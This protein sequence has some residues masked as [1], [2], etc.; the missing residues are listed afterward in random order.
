MLDR[1]TFGCHTM[2]Q[3]RHGVSAF[4]ADGHIRYVSHTVG[5]FD[6][7]QVVDKPVW[8]GSLDETAIEK[9][10]MQCVGYRT[11]VDLSTSTRAPDGQA[12]HFTYTFH[13]LPPNCR[14]VAVWHPPM[15]GQI[16]DARELECLRLLSQGLQQ[17]ELADK[18][19][20]SESTVKATLFSCRAK[21]NARTT[22]QAVAKATRHGLI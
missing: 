15:V 6:E 12:W 9:G 11:Q 21:L 3:R 17:S 13:P 16:L 10:F 4:D 7:Q 1:R 8:I 20:L 14:V 5:G 2:P 22:I 19:A 18:M